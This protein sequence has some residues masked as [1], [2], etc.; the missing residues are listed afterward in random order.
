MSRHYFF[1]MKVHKLKQNFCCHDCWHD[2][3]LVNFSTCLVFTNML[4]RYGLWLFQLFASTEK[5]NKWV[6]V[7][8]TN[9]YSDYNQMNRGSKG[10][11][12]T[13]QCERTERRGLWPLSVHPPHCKRPH[14]PS[15][16]TCDVM[17]QVGGRQPLLAVFTPAARVECRVLPIFWSSAAPQQWYL[18]RRGCDWQARTC[19]PPKGG[20]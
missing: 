3:I 6:G 8:T 18:I 5:C 12:V 9:V 14:K 7:W 2:H 17:Y 20:K 1:N 19:D 15:C 13:T 10:P 16:I 11:D 4:Y